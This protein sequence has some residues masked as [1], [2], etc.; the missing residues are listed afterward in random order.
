M[1]GAVASLSFT[2]QSCTPGEETTAMAINFIPNDPAAGSTAPAMGTINPR[3][4]RPATR[5]GFTFSNAAP[6]GVAPPG[7][8]QFLFWQAREAAI[9]AVQAFEASA[10]P[11]KAWQGNRKK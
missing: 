2:G 10:G 6:N 11:H 3:A 9:A 4:T 8:P 5:S 1:Q 7:T